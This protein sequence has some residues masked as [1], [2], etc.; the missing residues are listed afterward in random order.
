M[1]CGVRGTCV[2]AGHGH[3]STRA[4]NALLQSGPCVPSSGPSC[5]PESG[6]P[7]PSRPGRKDTAT[8]CESSCGTCSSSCARRRASII[9]EAPAPLRHTPKT[10]RRDAGRASQRRAAALQLSWSAQR[11]QAHKPSALVLYA[12]CAHSEGPLFLEL[13]EMCSE[14]HEMTSA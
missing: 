11:S 3:G 9:G 10:F 12:S 13:F 7:G 5:S 2:G 4:V 1:T 14:A 6:P 8:G